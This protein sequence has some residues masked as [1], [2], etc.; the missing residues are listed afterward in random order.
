MG[1]ARKPEN[2]NL[3]TW[4]QEPLFTGGYCLLTAEL[5]WHLN[6][7][8]GVMELGYSIKSTE[9]GDQVEL[10]S[11]GILGNLDESHLLRFA[12]T[13]I[14]ERAIKSLSPF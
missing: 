12:V 6:G 5:T 10:G 1:N 2:P 4:M 7:P 3:F 9:T 11:L 14:H 8:R 13:E